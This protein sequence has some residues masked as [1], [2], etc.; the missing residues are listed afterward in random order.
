MK[1]LLKIVFLFYNYIMEEL[2][3][4][5][6]VDDYNSVMKYITAGVKNTARIRKK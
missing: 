2:D 3:N 1:I 4:I 5:E 6:F